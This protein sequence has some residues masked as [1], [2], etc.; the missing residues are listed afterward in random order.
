V[1]AV[2]VEIDALAGLFAVFAAVLAEVAAG[3][4]HALAGRVGAFLELGHESLLSAGI[5]G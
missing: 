1:L 5:P 3:R 2:A 4:H